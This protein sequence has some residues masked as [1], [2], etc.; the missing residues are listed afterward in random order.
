VDEAGPQAAKSYPGKR[1]VNAQAT[2]AQPAKR[3]RQEID[4]GRR[5]KGYI[6]GALKPADGE[7]LTATYSGQTLVDWSDF[8][9]RLEAWIPQEVERVYVVL[10]NLTMHQA[11]DVLLFNLAHPRFEFAFQPTYAA[12]LNLIEP[13]WKTLR[14]LALRVV[15]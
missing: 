15:P 14:S 8:L 1:L 5:G 3:A 6:F 12:C 9:Q 10:D 2:Q 11:T 7:V 4:Y 13:W